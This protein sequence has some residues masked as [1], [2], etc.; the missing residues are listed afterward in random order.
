[1]ST[2][3]PPAADNTLAREALATLASLTTAAPNAAEAIAT[4]ERALA[5]ADEARAIEARLRRGQ[6][7]LARLAA[8]EALS[9]GAL[10]QAVESM[11][12]AACEVLGVARSS[13]WTYGAENRSIRCVDLFLD[14]DGVHERGV[15]LPSHTYPKY[16][17]ALATEVVIDAHDAH[18]DERTGEF[19]AG[20]LA[21]LGISSMLDAPIRVGGRMIGVLC[22]EHTGPG[23][24]WTADEMQFSSSLAALIA[25]AFEASERRESEAQ[26]RAVI[27]ALE[28]ERGH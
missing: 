10:E 12:E 27:E 19:S 23:R 28:A 18:T 25:L 7:A 5:H 20:Y 26:L 2:E 11:T 21:P 13:V 15:E 24:R 3:H 17:A 14:A 6:T 22:N 9:R 1:M 4:I 8:S 16:F